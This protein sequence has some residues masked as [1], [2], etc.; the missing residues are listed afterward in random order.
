MIELLVSE[1]RRVLDEKGYVTEEDFL[2]AWDAS[3]AIMVTERAWPHATTHRRDWRRAMN[4]A[5]KPE[6][7]AC[8]L[9]RPTGFF[10]WAEALAEAMD[11]SRFAGEELLEGQL[12]A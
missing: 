4:Q 5:L 1:K 10:K 12:V 7:C 9:G 6:A 3:W 8:F 11:E 2:L